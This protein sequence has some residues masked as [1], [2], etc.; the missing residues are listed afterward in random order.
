MR[1]I[2]NAGGHVGL[3]ARNYP[4]APTTAISAGQVVKLTAG[5][6]V[7]AVQAETNV[8]LGVAAENH[9]GVADALNIRANGGEI[10]VYDNP[11]LIFECPA[12]V[13]AAA[14]GSAT[15]IVPASGD[16]DANAAD[17]SFNNSVLMLISKAA[18]STNTDFIG[19]KIKVTDYAKTGTIITKDSGGTPSAGDKYEVYPQ[20]GAAVGGIAGLDSDTKSKL[21]VSTKG[22]T[23]I[24]CVGHDFDRHMIRLMAVEHALGG[25][26]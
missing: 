2:Q 4:I 22:A 1:P 10:L 11:E 21:V 18:E 9:P 17:D 24:K 8:I 12:P 3:S 16:V 25:T 6:V 13:I 15:T 26:N 19:K 7:S 20:I 5:L 14:S 23:K